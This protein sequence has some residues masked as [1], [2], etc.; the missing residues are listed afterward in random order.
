MLLLI[1]SK[2]EKII[3]DVVVQN[4]QMFVS[5]ESG[6]IER[7]I[8]DSGAPSRILRYLAKNVGDTIGY[9]VIAEKVGASVETV[10]TS[11]KSIRTLLLDSSTHEIYVEWTIN[12]GYVRLYE[13]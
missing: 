8:P 7:W 1:M 3:G 2:T 13:T 12:G 10:R 5:T 4:M 11:T 6:E 9:G